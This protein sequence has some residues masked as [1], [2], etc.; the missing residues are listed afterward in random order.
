MPD[1][2]G[3]LRGRVEELNALGEA[4]G[5]TVDVA[6]VLKVV[7]TGELEGENGGGEE[8][9]DAEDPGEICAAAPGTSREGIWCWMAVG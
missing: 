5:E 6:G 8:E 9:E 2:G 1:G 7:A 4:R 3:G